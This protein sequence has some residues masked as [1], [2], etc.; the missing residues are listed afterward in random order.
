MSNFP[1]LKNLGTLHK[2]E[3]QF[4]KPRLCVTDPRQHGV[5]MAWNTFIPHGINVCLVCALGVLWIG[6]LVLNATGHT[7]RELRD[8]ACNKV[9]NEIR[10]RPDGNG[11]VAM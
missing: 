10:N 7:V 9:V 2:N 6:G 11:F 4:E 1:F 5:E 8:P 3:T